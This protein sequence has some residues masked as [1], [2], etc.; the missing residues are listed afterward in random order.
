VTSVIIAPDSFKGS[1]GAREV[2]EAVAAGW[3]SV[4]PTDD[5]RILPQADGGEGT[6]DAIEAAVPGSV[7]HDVGPVT[8]PDGRPVSGVWLE[9][10]G[11]VGVVELAQ[12]CGLPLMREL[13]PLG[14]TTLGL[15]E[16]IR[17]A[18]SHG[19][20]RLV[21]GLGGSASTDG[22]AGA[23]AALGLRGASGAALPAGG[24]SHASLDGLDR[25]AL[26]APPPGGVVLLSDVSA[27]LLGPAGAAAVFGP[28]KG[29]TPEQVATLDA[30]LAR[31]ASLLGGDTTVPGAGA[32]GGAGY[33]F[34]AA[35]G[36]TM[37]SGADY[38]AKLSGLPQAV[39][40]ADVLLTGEGRF[41]ATSSTGKVVGQVIRLAAGHDARVGVIAGQI[42]AEPVDAGGDRLWSAALVDLAG[43]VEAAMADPARWLREAGAA[44]S[45]ALARR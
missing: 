29:A 35:W 13:D 7:R 12:S 26:L 1:L 23:L 5:I 37:E 34:V 19:I 27:P 24:G 9:L 44:A 36:A 4:R 15:G 14:A 21:I 18:I 42:A 30:G 6:L 38:L 43:S 39:A 2:A 45:R 16:V 22:G 20:G 31:F 32:A 40:E 17:A 3:S 25:R 28:Q 11:G 33:G 10:P 41:D 8:G